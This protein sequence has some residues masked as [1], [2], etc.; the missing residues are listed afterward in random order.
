MTEK[1]K[2][3]IKRLEL[4]KSTEIYVD[5]KRKEKTEDIKIVL[6]LLNE[7]DKIIELMAGYIATND[8]NFCLYLN[9]TTKC[10]QGNGKTCDECIKQYFE[11][12]VKE[13]K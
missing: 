9:V 11:D 4:N 3:A 12:R 1:Q 2:L 8:I 10:E 5:Y 6:E 7:K 13:E